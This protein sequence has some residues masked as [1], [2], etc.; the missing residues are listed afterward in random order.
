MTTC[1]I[2]MVNVL[3]FII[4]EISVFSTPNTLKVQ[5]ANLELSHNFFFFFTISGLK[6]FSGHNQCLL[7]H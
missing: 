4:N 2:N 5:K 7:K 1:A 3:L 6:E